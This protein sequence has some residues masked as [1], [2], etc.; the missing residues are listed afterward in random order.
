MKNLLV[1][2]LV[3]AAPVFAQ[4]GQPERSETEKAKSV[5]EKWD[6]GELGELDTPLGDFHIGG[7][8]TFMHKTLDRY[9]GGESENFFD[10]IRIVPQFEWHIVDWLSFGMEIEFEG[11]GA[12]AGFLSDNEILI[13]YA[14]A[15]VTPLDELNFKAGILLIPF[16]RYNLNH[17]DINW[18]LADR[19]YAARR[20]VPSA[21][22]QPGVGVYGTFNQV[23]FVSFSYDVSITQGFDD[24][25][26]NN[27]GARD[28]RQSFREDNNG[29]KAI[30][31][32]LGILPRIDDMGCN[33]VRADFGFSYT[34]QEIGPDNTQAL[35]GGAIDGNIAIDVI[36]RFRID[37][38]GEATRLW[39]NR[40]SSNTT[41]NGLW[42]YFVDVTFKFD[43]FPSEWRGTTFGSNP[44]IGLIF[45]LEQN[46]LNDDHVGAAARD[47]RIGMTIGLSFRPISKFV[48]RAE[49]K[50]QQS[51]SRDDG[52]E[53]RLVLSISIGF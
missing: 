7:Y 52:D 10:A 21:F 31:A 3:A 35:R 38:T 30:W 53:T 34:Y 11:G 39:I 32:R 17:D 37:I 13:E 25:F 48:V 29:N 23:P 22:D 18:D 36:E 16:G 51:K 49:M 8:A 28:A 42:G 27:G 19:P 14:E 33:M 1:L 20:V 12:D 2:L 4:D 15:R 26:T 41:P 45:R 43:P 44:Y 47:D 24:Q 40:P 5:V 9:N 6:D 46:D 50:H